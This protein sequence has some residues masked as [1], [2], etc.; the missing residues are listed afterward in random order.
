MSKLTPLDHLKMLN[1]SFV[2]YNS[3]R[4]VR[5]HKEHHDERGEPMSKCQCGHDELAHLGGKHGKR[6]KC[7]MDQRIVPKEEGVRYRDAKSV[8]SEDFKKLFATLSASQKARAIKRGYVIQ[9]C[10]CPYY[11]EIDIGQVA[12]IK[13]VGERTHPDQPDF[14]HPTPPPGKLIIP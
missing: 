4:Y 13:P 9:S 7:V 2:E 10:E 11:H 5:G 8:S 14:T 12:I 6:G 1:E 3:E